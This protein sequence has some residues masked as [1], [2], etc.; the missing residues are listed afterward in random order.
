MLRLALILALVAG[1]AALGVSQFVVAKKIAEKDETIA[2]T[3]KEKDDAQQAASKAQ[4]EAKKA[5]AAQKATE[6]ERDDFKAQFESSSS[7]AKVQ[8]K[9]AE[10]AE[11]KLAKE[12]EVR[13]DAQQQL[14][15][16]NAL[17]IPVDQIKVLKSDLLK[18]T[19]ERDAHIAEEKV[20]NRNI[21]QLQARVAIYEGT[22][23][24]VV[25]PA[26][27]RGKVTNVDPNYD[28]V[29]LNVGTEQGALP[30]GEMLVSRDGKLVAKVRLVRVQSKESIANVLPE[31]KQVDVINGDMVLPAL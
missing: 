8:R 28:F 10:D 30:N 27:L 31:W 2:T 11:T 23:H 15:A 16:W 14:A 1:L 25:L 5:L 12:T 9:R 6:K 24:K 13:T 18:V 20:L 3:T 17:G 21:T 7:D 29:V 26:S 19:K 22:T 4:G